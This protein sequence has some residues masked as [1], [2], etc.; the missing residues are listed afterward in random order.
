MAQFL[1][2]QRSILTRR[3][4]TLDEH[5]P[6]SHLVRFVWRIL[7]SFDFTALEKLYQST[8]GG[9]GRP[10]YH[11]RILAA[12]WI[13]GMAEG[14]QT[15]A[16]VAEACTNRDDFRW[17]MSRAQLPNSSRPKPPSTTR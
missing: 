17:L 1:V 11:P 16:S 6:P 10:P 15:A 7:E 12:L 8:Y 14:F 2:P 3:E 5:I 13:Y 4:G 9:P